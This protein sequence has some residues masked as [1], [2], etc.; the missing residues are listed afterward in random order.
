MD[1]KITLSTTLDLLRAIDEVITQSCLFASVS[2]E[3]V[4]TVCTGRIRPRIQ[5]VPKTSLR[6]VFQGLRFSTSCPLCIWHQVCPRATSSTCWQQKPA[7]TR[8]IPSHTYSISTRNNC[9][10]EMVPVVGDE[11]TGMFKSQDGSGLIGSKWKSWTTHPWRSNQWRG[12][13]G[14]GRSAGSQRRWSTPLLERPHRE[15]RSTNRCTTCRCRTWWSS[16]CFCC[17]CSS[18]WKSSGGPSSGWLSYTVC[19]SAGRSAGSERPLCQSSAA[20]TPE[21]L[22]RWRSRQGT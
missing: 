22:S 11:K 12:G 13:G 18:Q 6:L 1:P 15:P 17:Q 4:S 10:P 5:R 7:Q 20:N 2:S 16:A 14:W 19:R 9:R 8:P 21:P 3:H